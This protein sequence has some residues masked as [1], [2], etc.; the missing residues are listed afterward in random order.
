VPPKG[1]LTTQPIARS[2]FDAISFHQCNIRDGKI[3]ILPDLTPFVKNV[4]TYSSSERFHPTNRPA[5]ISSPNDISGDV[6]KMNSYQIATHSRG[7]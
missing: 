6:K 5:K 3:C 2:W 7:A 4:L 1:N